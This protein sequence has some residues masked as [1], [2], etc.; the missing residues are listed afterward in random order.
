MEKIGETLIAM[1]MFSMAW[2]AGLAIAVGL[3]AFAR[4]G[5]QAVGEERMSEIFCNTGPFALFCAGVHL[6]I[7][8]EKSADNT[9][10]N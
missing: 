8:A 10:S 1:I 5:F 3:I 4:N 7:I 6:T 2:C 9:N